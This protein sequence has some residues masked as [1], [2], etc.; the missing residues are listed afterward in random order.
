M[1][2]DL[3]SLSDTKIVIRTGMAS[4]VTHPTR[5]NN[6]LDRIYLS[7]LEYE[8]VNVMKSA[9][10][11]DHM[12]VVVYSG[13]SLKTVNKRRRV[14]TFRK[15][16]SAEHAN[17]L[18]G[19]SDSSHPASADS[20]GDLQE[21]DRL[22]QVLNELM[23]H[24]YPTRRVTITSTDPPYITPSVKYMLRCK[25]RLMRAGNLEQAAAL[26]LKIVGAIKQ[27]TSAE[28]C[29]VDVI[30][31]PRSMWVKVRQLTGRCSKAGDDAINSTV[32]AEILNNHHAAILK[33]SSYRTPCTKST[34]NNR[35]ALNAIT[36]W[37]IFKVLDGLKCTA[38][39]L[40]NIPA[41]FLKIGAPFFA[42]PIANV[43]NL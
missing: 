19:V 34:V 35:S 17:F 41:W 18:A 38:A 36:E 42:T 43:M 25:N 8:A 30:A 37:R 10:K 1:A 39:G 9:V 22:C 26:A 24:Y 23:D 32:T 7:D 28:L 2:G 6:I 33:D 3:N 14:C 15:H 16:T 4:I 13:A 5:G 31:D 11:S 21:V 40:D 27:F 20:S 29:Q 12:A